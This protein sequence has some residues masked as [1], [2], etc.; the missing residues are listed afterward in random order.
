MAAI[1]TKW[2]LAYL[3][4]RE[5][6]QS[7][8]VHK[9]DSRDA[10]LEAYAYLP[11]AFNSAAPSVGSEEGPENRLDADAIATGWVDALR[12]PENKWL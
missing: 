12:P 11:F 4:Y 8:E 3:E 7:R 9:A 2:Q 6:V 5:Y 1:R 10:F